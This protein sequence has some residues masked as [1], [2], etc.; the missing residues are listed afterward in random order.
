MHHKHVFL[1]NESSPDDAACWVR[2]ILT[3][4]TLAYNACDYGTVIGIL[5]LETGEY[6][7]EEKDYDPV[8]DTIEKLEDYANNLFGM[9]NV[10]ILKNKLDYY[11]KNN[12]YWNASEI[13]KEIDGIWYASNMRSKWTAKQPFPI[14]DGYINMCGVTDWCDCTSV[15]CANKAKYA[16]IVD[17]HS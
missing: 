6:T 12:F 9:D 13:C 17:F 7:H 4:G 10:E 15:G 14:C 8:I 1:S 16:V 11:L 5:D 3:D 2:D